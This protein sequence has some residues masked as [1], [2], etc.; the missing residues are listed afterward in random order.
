MKKRPILASTSLLLLSLLLASVILFERRPLQDRLLDYAKQSVGVEATMG[1]VGWQWLPLPA[2]TIRQVKAEGESFTL[3]LPEA[4]LVLNPTALL[5]GEMSLHRVKLIRPE[6]VIKSSFS[7]Q[8]QPSPPSSYF[9]EK[10]GTITSTLQ[11]LIPA[12]HLT[13]VNGSVTLPEQHLSPSLALK[14][15]RLTEINGSI[16]S[17]RSTVLLDVSANSPFATSL[18]IKGSI[19]P[20]Q[21]SYQVDFAGTA[22]NSKELFRPLSTQQGDEES[23]ATK[24]KSSLISVE[25]LTVSAH[26]TGLGKNRFELKINSKN[27]PFSVKW[28]EQTFHIS[29]IDNLSLSR[30]E[31]N[32]SLD[33]TGLSLQEPRLRLQGHLV[34]H[35]QKKNTT[36]TP[37]WIIDLNGTDLDLAAI[38][39]SILAN[40]SDNHA[41]QQV[42]AIVLGGSATS[43]RFTFQ[44][45][46]TDLQHLGKMQIWADA[47]DVPITIPT[48]NLSIDRASGPISIVDDVLRGENL[49][50]TID[51]TQ[52][53][54]GSLLVNLAK[55]KH[56]FHL[57]L[58]L[59]ADLENLHTVLSQI[60]PSTKFHNE[61]AR[62]KQIKG[63]AQGHLRLGDDLHHIKTEVEVKKMLASGTYD[64]MPWPFTISEGELQISHGPQGLGDTAEQVVWNK[65][66]GRIGKQRIDNSTGRVS[67]QKGFNITISS[68]DADLDL[69]SF[70][71]E[72]S[73]RTNKGTIVFNDFA[74]GRFDDLAGQAKLR[75]SSFSGLLQ[76]PDQWKF[77]STLTCSDLQL[78]RPGMLTLSSKNI[79]AEVDQERINFNGIFSLFDQELFLS[80]HHTHRLFKQFHGEL[81]I[82]GE[83]GDR[84]L[85]WLTEQKRFPLLSSL[86]HPFRVENCILKNQGATNEPF[87][88]SG[89]IIA[90]PQENGIKAQ[91]LRDRQSNHSID[92]VTLV[93]GKTQGILSHQTWPTLEKRDLLTWQGEVSSAT[94]DAL[95]NQSFLQSG[96]LTGA[97]SRLSEQNNTTY[98]G[99]LIAQDLRFLPESPTP[100]LTIDT[101]HLQANQDTIDIKQA[102]VAVSGIPVAMTGRILAKQDTHT[103][104]LQVKAPQLSWRSIK[105]PFDLF[106]MRKSTSTGVKSAHNSLQGTIKFDIASFDYI[107]QKKVVKDAPPAGDGEKS[108]RPDELESHTFTSTPFRGRM[109]FT[110]AGIALQIDKSTV[111]GIDNQGTWH[112]GNEN[113]ENSISFT[114]GKTPLSFEKTLSCLGIKQ[115]LIIGPFSVEG[116]LV[117][118]AKKWRQGN[119]TLVS[120]EGLIRRMMLL[121]KIFTAVNFTDY[122][123]TWHDLPNMENE[124]LFYN[125]LSIKAHVNDN[126]LT[127]DRTV[128][129]GKGVN[130]SGRGTIDLTDMDSDLTFF[131]APF[132]SLD[133]FVKNL[134]LIGT[135]LAGPK[136]SILTFP[137]SVTGNIKS[138]EVTALAPRAIGSAILDL[139]T[140]TLTLPFR[141]FQPAEESP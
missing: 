72:G 103:L 132:K 102:D 128:I 58:D 78:T 81:E 101:L 68:L 85:E 87:L 74:R 4:K 108:I 99:S 23:P 35:L 24:E 54:N 71:G 53:T 137:V 79:E 39:Q 121:S 83:I 95:F 13:I 69:K 19:A 1:S 127:L 100:D 88:S 30:H 26:L 40:F 43:A 37:E 98:N 61:L 21:D 50:A 57:E 77:Q 110:P 138:P 52:G 82:N 70:F 105:K 31:D 9:V 113:K 131:I 93:N 33:L 17:H 130:L 38:R 97:F 86:K 122:L 5:S 125:D 49:H 51:K 75:K 34:R 140:D 141:I 112:F 91:F 117:G 47:K 14:A 104:D 25:G 46:G 45:S 66:R 136:E 124:G 15:M 76:K 11:R 134:P 60:I 3:V 16:S 28:L 96:R 67:W 55:D 63:Q 89:T 44:G 123:T 8:A 10:K 126:V 92:T 7:K 84:L 64:R 118:Q 80:G 48:L 73:L 18:Q 106:N 29:N 59:D 135:A 56:D 120:S 65:V 27:K 119:V 62:F 115:S 32:F 109:D 41:A 129:K 6:L 42:C 20:L 116:Q 107:Q 36:S 22:I 114:S 12:D 133:W 90:L 139:F 111:C 94:I 2:I